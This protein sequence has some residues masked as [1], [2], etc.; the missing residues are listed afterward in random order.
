MLN[1]KQKYLLIIILALQ[2]SGFYLHKKNIH[3]GTYINQE[4]IHQLKPNMTKI[5]V[6]NIIGYPSLTPVIAT[7]EWYYYY[8]LKNQYNQI[9]QKKILLL[10]FEKN[11]LKSYLKN[12]NDN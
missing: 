1:N 7:N 4:K 8:Y 3:Q 2:L 5:E 12:F 9:I 6:Q 10:Y 11:K